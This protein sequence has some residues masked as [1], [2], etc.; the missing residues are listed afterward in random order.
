MRV[1]PWA[2]LFQDLQKFWS[3]DSWEPIPCIGMNQ[4]LAFAP[5]MVLTIIKYYGL[6]DSLETPH[7]ILPGFPIGT[8][9]LESVPQTHAWGTPA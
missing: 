7:W 3:S 8:I 6:D 1:K 9:R 4:L 2:T 5:S